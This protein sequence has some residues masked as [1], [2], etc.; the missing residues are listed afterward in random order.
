MERKWKE[1]RWTQQKKQFPL[2]RLLFGFEKENRQK[3]GEGGNLTPSARLHYREKKT[4][5]DGGNNFI[6][7]L[8]S[9][10]R[11]HLDSIEKT[12]PQQAGTKR[13]GGGN[14]VIDRKRRRRKA[15]WAGREPSSSPD[16]SVTSLH[17]IYFHLNLCHH[18]DPRPAGAA[19]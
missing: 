7:G 6:Q 13:G 14:K 12:H 10:K 5:G 3:S 2:S 16:K 15:V 18:L 4:M 17:S 11:I 8:S 9:H 1:G 19:E